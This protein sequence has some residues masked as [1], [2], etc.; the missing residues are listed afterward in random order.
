MRQDDEPRGEKIKVRNVA[1]GSAENVV[2]AG[3][4]DEVHIYQQ[5]ASSLDD[6]TKELALTVRAQ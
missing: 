3:S 4:I 1:S 2:Q 6:V 5:S